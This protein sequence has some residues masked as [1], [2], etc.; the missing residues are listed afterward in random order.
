MISIISFVILK[1]NNNILF[2]SL[3]LKETVD[4]ARKPTLLENTA[5]YRAPG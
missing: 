4:T 5:A 2:I 1:Y 3:H